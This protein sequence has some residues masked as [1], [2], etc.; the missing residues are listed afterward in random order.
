VP[1]QPF[2]KFSDLLQ[3]R[4]PED[5]LYPGVPAHIELPLRSWIVRAL[6]GGGAGG[7]AVL[8]RLQIDYTTGQDAATFLATM[9]APDLLDVVQAILYSGGPWPVREPWTG[10]PKHGARSGLQRE[11]E[12]IF[13][14]GGSAYRVNDQFDGL[15][16]RVDE[17]ATAAAALAA[18]A[19]EA[20]PRSG[21]AGDQ[22]RAA[23]K[24]I[25]KP[26]PEPE[27][28]YRQAVKAVES[29]AHAV[30]QPNHADATL[31]TMRG[32]LRANAVRWTLAIPGKDGTGSIQPLVAML[33]LLWDGQEWR[34]GGQLPE[35]DATPEEAETA[36]H[37][38]ATLVHWFVTG[39]V[40]KR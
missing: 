14:T 23:W 31:G 8:L 22:L 9:A 4:P 11:I 38:A 7:I 2:Q 10:T 12:Q 24:A 33:G 21:S 25:Y 5:V 15:E 26:D 17:T 37:L 19:A 20:N 18:S 39:A 13:D 1:Q 3:G 6:G 36:V 16:R 29:A 40:R 32:E 35:R 34:H 30:V 28:A 27:T